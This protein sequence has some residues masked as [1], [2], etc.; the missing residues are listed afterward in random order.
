MS[1]MS[2]IDVNS[3]VNQMMS[4]DQ[5]QLN[6]LI[7]K[8]QI[9]QWTQDRYQSITTNLQ[10]FSNN[11]FDVLSNNYMLSSSGYSVNAATSNNANVT[12]TASNTATVGTYNVSWTQ[13]AT[14][15]Q[16]NTTSALPSTI[17]NSST[18]STVLASNSNLPTSGT[19]NFT[20]NGTN[21]TYDLSANSGQSLSQVLSSLSNGCGATFSYSELTGKFSIADDTTGSGQYLTISSTDANTQNFLNTLFGTNLS[22]TS[23]ATT[24][25]TIGN[26]G[27]TNNL[28]T[29]GQNGSFTITEPNG[30]TNSTPLSEA[31]NK[32]Q[33]DGV[34]YNIAQNGGSSGSANISVTSNVSSVVT[35]IQNFVNDYNNL[36]GGISSVT[37]ET[38]NYS[39]MPLS[40][41]QESQM[42]ASEI[43]A[44]NQKAQQGLLAN[45]DTL[46]SMLDSMRE[47][48]YTPVNG[49]G[50]SMADVGLSTSD[51]P[52][53]GGKLTLDTT[54]LTQAL[55]NNPQ[56][57]ISLFT[58]MSSSY[59]VFNTDLTNSQMT[60]RSSEEG[61]F[62]RLSDIETQYAGTYVDANGNQGILL[63][64]AGMP[65]T[66]SETNNS[67]F[68]E[69][70]DE[71]DSITQ[72]K[73]KMA[74][75]QTM[76]T[77]EFTSL[78]SALSQMSTQ[79]SYLSSM[80]SS[81]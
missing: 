61:I 28:G 50:L 19:L 69:I 32:F 46:N 48:F 13:L 54:K 49:I 26:T 63:Q 24:T 11:Y 64:K 71:Q 25:N 35:K 55:Q 60:T 37:S 33:I 9:S 40:S 65:N 15:A 27:G 80:L 21:V 79:Q 12:A 47:A 7:Q 41:Q 56:Q 70:A 2:G 29:A 81:G 30:S 23:G 17:N 22:G 52:T 58:Q 74:Q 8:E 3:M 1:Q 38:R 4:S 53:Q 67:L 42:T 5:I 75:D 34:T 77:N 76:Y 72:F 68:K 51:D 73:T 31:S 14:A 16:L 66:T 59:P 39:Y 45:D 18:L 20:V 78:Q 57:V 43:T 44:W 36:I 10:N 6:Q 62:Q